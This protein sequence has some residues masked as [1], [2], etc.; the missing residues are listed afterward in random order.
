MN[1]KRSFIAIAAFFLLALTA[2][3]QRIKI[4]E[5]DISPLKGEKSINTDFTYDDLKIG[6][7]LSEAEYIDK[8]KDEFNKKEAGRGDRWSKEWVS[9]RKDRYEPKFNELFS[10]AS[11]IEVTG[12]KKNA[13]Y[14]LIYKT[15]YIEP[16]YNIGITSHNAVTNAEAWIVEA[17]TQK[18][19]A[20]LSVE[21]A[22]GRSFWGAD[23]DTGARIAECY[24]DAGKALGAFIRKKS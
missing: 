16:G 13:K 15:T 8:K 2:G 14:T 12:A 22:Q 10:K 6:K 9:D 7:N 23:F 11:E 19:I 18:V 4:I 3:A 24:A 17:G 20:K 5:G 21:K 1:F